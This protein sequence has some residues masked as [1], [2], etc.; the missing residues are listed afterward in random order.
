MVRCEAWL[1]IGDGLKILKSASDPTDLLRVHQKLCWVDNLTSSEVKILQWAIKRSILV[2]KEVHR[3][4]N[5]IHCEVMK[6]L[7][8]L[9]GHNSDRLRVESPLVTVQEMDWGIGIEGESETDVCGVWVSVTHAGQPAE[10][11]RLNG[12]A[13]E[14][15]DDL[16][17]VY[18]LSCSGV[19]E[20]LEQLIT[21]GHL[22]LVAEW[23]WSC[24]N[25]LLLRAWERSL[26]EKWDQMGIIDCWSLGKSKIK[27]WSSWQ[28]N[29]C[30]NTE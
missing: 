9:V 16:G 23:E 19:D 5:V 12:A 30:S 22:D 3:S 2:N 11:V 1:P 25:L 8:T 6:C 29:L 21:D 24:H 13:G 7:F 18:E 10:E 26:R 4:C 28:N 20:G 14:V 15:L 17:Q 27:N